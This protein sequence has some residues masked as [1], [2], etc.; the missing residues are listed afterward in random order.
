MDASG[1]AALAAWVG[2]IPV[3]IAAVK[4]L[5]GAGVAERRALRAEE[6][7]EEAVT[8]FER[9]ADALDRLADANAGRSALRSVAPVEFQ[10]ERRSKNGYSL[11]NLGPETA[12]NV[13]VDASELPLSRD[14]P[15]GITLAPMQSHALLLLGA[16]QAPLPAELKVSC[17]QFDEQIHVP[18]PHY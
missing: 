16:W 11:R 12:T 9:M 2:L 3:G 8:Q 14:L 18:V 1:W 7:A 6:R 17:D 4:A 13:V 10:I 15:D 5:K